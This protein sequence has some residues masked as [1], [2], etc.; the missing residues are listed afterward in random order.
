[1]LCP[2]LYGDQLAYAAGP[3][4]REEGCFAPVTSFFLHR[5][6]KTSSLSS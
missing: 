3:P 5:A 2:P 4:V 6:Q 1:L